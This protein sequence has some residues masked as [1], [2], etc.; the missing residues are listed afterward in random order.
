M[1]KPEQKKTSRTI[2]SLQ[3]KAKR[4]EVKALFQLAEHY[5]Q[6]KYVEQDQIKADSYYTQALA[7]F[8]VQSL[9]ISTARLVCYRC[10][11]QLDI[12]FS[13][14][15]RDKSNLT[16]I[17]GDNGAGKT[18]ILTAL[19]N[20]LSWLT[21]KIKSEKG[22]GVKL[23][24]QDIHNASSAEYATI[25][26]NLAVKE[27]LN[28]EVVLAKAKMAS[29]V[30]ISN[31]FA[32]VQQLADI[33]RL[34][35]AKNKQ[36]NFPIMAYYP[37]E[38]SIEIGLT[39]IRQFSQF[40]EKKS[41]DKF[42]GYEDALNSAAN[43]KSFYAWFKHFEDIENEK[44]SPQQS[45]QA[46]INKL[47]IERET[48]YTLAQV[49][50]G[51]ISGGGDEYIT[52]LLADKDQQIA[53]LT[54]QLNA[55]SH[56]QRGKTLDWVKKAI[57]EF[58]SDFTHLRIQRS[59]YPDML[60]DKNDVTLSVLQLSQ[61]ERSLLA[62]VGDIARRLVLLNPSRENPL[63]G[64]GV[65]LIDEIDLHLHPKWQQSV[66]PNLLNTFPNIQFITTTHSPQVLTTVPNEC[67]RVLSSDGVT[68]PQVQTLGEESR[69]T[70]EDV[71]H[72]DS[73]P[74]DPMSVL[75]KQYLEAVNRGDI[76]SADVLAMR[77]VLVQ[78]YGTG[79]SQ[80]RLADMA[81]NRHRAIN[82]TRLA[83]A[84]P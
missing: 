80:L 81:I 54:E 2:R 50:Q 31:V 58:V 48:I 13:N 49:K 15:Y 44:N 35:N 17:V 1:N 11:D 5:E 26:V 83:K 21:G 20:G 24:E 64:D 65:V 19:A 74:T 55:L 56:A 36:F 70:L 28:Y 40:S 60:I 39:D 77:K 45:L 84:K 46:D 42:D 32:D 14:R 51:D 79:N 29:N 22:Q 68:I 61:G 4:K 8:D 38:R 57:N 27:N 23:K 16:V 33:Y 9:Q 72:V 34:A 47:Q 43:F 3:S 67:I 66:L 37:V 52:S 12:K 78:H 69:T 63:E 25:I 76:E 41:W 62:L 59:P 30:S 7:L 71:M 53:V 82:K 75:L 73:R 6:G 18:T 10:Y